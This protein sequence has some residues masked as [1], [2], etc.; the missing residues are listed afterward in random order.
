V[1]IGDPLAALGGLAL[2]AIIA[3]YFLKARRRAHV[4]GSTLW[5]RPLALDR[6]ANTPWQRLRPSWLLALQLF[7]AALVVAALVQ[8]A[9]ATSK[10]LGGQ[11]IV[12]IDAS[13]T[14]QATDVAPSRFAAA[15][16]DARALIDRL[17]PRGRMTLIEMSASPVVLASSVGDRQPLIAGLDR[18]RPTSGP[19]DL[20]DALQL[21]VASAGPQPKATQLVVLSDGVTEPLPGPISVPFPIVYRRIGVSAEDVGVGALDIVPGSA[22]PLAVARVENFGQLPARL[23]V[24]MAADGELYAAKAVD[25]AGGSAQDVTFDVPPAASYVQASLT[26]PGELAAGTTATAIVAPPR[27]LRALLVTPGD[28]FLEDAL[29]LRTDLAVSTEAPSAWRDS[30]ATSTSYDLVVFDGFVPDKLP[31]ATPYLLVGPP[32]DRLVGAGRPVSPGPLLPAEQDDPLLDDVDLS[33]VDVALSSNLSGSRF[34]RVVITSQA[35][36]VLMVRDPSAESPG[37]AVLGIY[38]H[39]SDL[40]LRD[41]WPVLLTHLSEFLAPGTVPT[42][43]QV[44]GSQVTIAPGPGTK[45]VMVALPDGQEDTLAG[46]QGGGTVVF[47]DTSQTGVYRITSISATGGR[48]VSYLAVNAPAT[49]ITP[50]QTLDVTG[51]PGGQ[52]VTTSLYRGLWPVLAVAA[53]LVLLAEWAVYQR[54][55]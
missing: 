9:F 23:T 48:Q 39:D 7:A 33:N 29:K 34:G 19:A 2:V 8:P 30:Q 13:E 47:G 50:Q 42:P 10:A 38:L 17:G 53:L 1:E 12:V 28:I 27:T 5:W 36:P 6:Q 21:A 55:H 41:A 11:T 54:A 26:P 20:Q 44:P 49:A 51:T 3:L 31:T 16:A 22:G 52:A 46:V 4:V 40:V 18:L 32:P 43:G 24:E 25:I 35:G 15:V 14:M 45:E 37:A